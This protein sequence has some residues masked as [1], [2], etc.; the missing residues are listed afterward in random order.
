MV[1]DE[2]TRCRPWITDALEYANGT[3]LFDD[4]AAMIVAGQ[5]QLWPAPR[6]CL[7]TEIVTYPR[8][9]IFNVFLAG[10]ELDQLLDMHE[11]MKRWAKAQGCTVATLHGRRGWTRTLAE[12]GW[13]ETLTTMERDLSHV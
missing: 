13:R 4:V 8:K 11:D 10:G 2:I 9:R 6:G 12:N 7:V 1:L 3:H 5:L